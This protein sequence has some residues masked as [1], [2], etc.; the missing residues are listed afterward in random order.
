MTS[1]VCWRNSFS[2]EQLVNGGAMKRLKFLLVTSVSILIL[3]LSGN[4]A[5][6]VWPWILGLWTGMILAEMSYRAGKKKVTS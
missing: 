1:V 6:P 4:G 5:H 3:I 2:G